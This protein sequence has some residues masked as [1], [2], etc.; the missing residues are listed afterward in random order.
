MSDKI[1]SE[2]F[3]VSN[4]SGMFDQS[5][6]IHMF[7]SMASGVTAFDENTVPQNSDDIAS[8]P[9]LTYDVSNTIFDR[10][11]T[12]SASIWDYSKSWARVEEVKNRIV[13]LLKDGGY[14]LRAGTCALWVTP[15]SP[16]VQRVGDE[17][18][19]IRRI[20]INVDIEP[21]Q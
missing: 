19:M 18:D 7:W 13:S 9:R 14:C 5:Q 8:F 15:G 6:M 1:M 4:R 2:Q 3:N 12:I 17:N 21:L 11:V 16:F 20:L 10:P